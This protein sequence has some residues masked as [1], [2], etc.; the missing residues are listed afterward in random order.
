MKVRVSWPH[1]LT[2]S[3]HAY[4]RWKE[5]WRSAWP[6]AVA[7]RDFQDRVKQAVFVEE[8]TGNPTAFWRL[9]EEDGRHPLIVVDGFGEV[10][11]VLTP[12]ACKPNRRPRK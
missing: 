5:R 8:D 3:E 9:P 7:K 10:K 1:P 4:E 2:I 12:E 6:W 11:T